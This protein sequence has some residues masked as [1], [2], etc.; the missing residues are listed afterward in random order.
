MFMT[1]DAKETWKTQ[2]AYGVHKTGEAQEM[3]R[4]TKLLSNHMHSKKML[5]KRRY[6]EGNVYKLD[7]KFLGY[8][9]PVS[10]HMLL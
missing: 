1:Q 8:I 2:E 3:T 7:R 6:S 5:R 10:L 9:F 4:L